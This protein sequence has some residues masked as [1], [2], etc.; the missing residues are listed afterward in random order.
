MKQLFFLHVQ[1]VDRIKRAFGVIAERCLQA[2]VQYPYH[3]L[4]AQLQEFLRYHL[5][6]CIHLKS[7]SLVDPSPST[8][9]FHGRTHQF[10][11]KTFQFRQA[12][13]LAPEGSPP[14][15]F[16]LTCFKWIPCHFM[17]I[18][19]DL[20]YIIRKHN[21][22]VFKHVLCIKY[23]IYS[24]GEEN[25]SGVQQFYRLWFLINFHSNPKL[26]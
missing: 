6:L 4:G 26:H 12:S 17:A 25:I 22:E 16:I 11:N 2:L 5:G 19:V 15:L 9:R 23:H 10:S 13:P 24:A 1:I 21:Q 8:W 7:T 3:E 18:T 20:F 14:I